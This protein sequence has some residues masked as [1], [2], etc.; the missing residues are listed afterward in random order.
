MFSFWHH[1]NIKTRKRE[2]WFCSVDPNSM[3][4]LLWSHRGHLDGSI[5][6]SSGAM[7]SIRH[8][9][10]YRFDVDVVYHIDEF[11]GSVYFY[12]SHPS[13]FD[14]MH[15]EKY[16]HLGTFLSSLVAHRHHLVEGSESNGQGIMATLEPKFFKETE[17]FQKFL[18]HVNKHEAAPLCG[19]IVRFKDDIDRIK[20]LS[21][22]PLVSIGKSFIS[23]L[24]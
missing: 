24:I 9:G 2:S 14:T 8:M 10:V 15:A 1:A 12:I 5:E 19:I 20:S 4:S 23:P 21:P 18:E 3:N 7:A 17:I 6:G 16:Q 22:M 13:E 11:S